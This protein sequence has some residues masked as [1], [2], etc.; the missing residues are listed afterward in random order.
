MQMLRL[1][2]FSYCQ[3]QTTSR[4]TSRNLASLQSTGNYQHQWNATHRDSLMQKAHGKI[5]LLLMPAC[6]KFQIL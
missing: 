2:V 3:Q 1:G 5:L 6:E 4:L